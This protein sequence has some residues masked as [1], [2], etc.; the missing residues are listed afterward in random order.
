M[1]DVH[2]HFRT[3]RTSLTHP[4]PVVRAVDGVDLQ[5]AA[6]ETL[7]LVGESGCGKSTLARMANRLLKPTSG[8][9]SVDGRDI[10]KLSS[11][12]LRPVRRDVAM[13]FQDPYASLNP[14]QSVRQIIGNAFRAQSMSVKDAEL[15]TLVERVG[16]REAHLGRYPHEFSGGQRQ[17]IGLAR[18][19]ALQPKLVIADEPTSALDVSVRA[20]VLNLLTDLQEE[21]GLSYLLVT[22]DLAVVK[23]YATR[24]AVMYLGRMVE[25][26]PAGEIFET[27]RHPYTVALRSAVPEPDPHSTRERI[28]LSGEPPSPLSVPSGCPFRTRCWKAQDICAVETPPLTGSPHP[29]ACHFP[30]S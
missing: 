16:L 21:L 18:A 24:V 17:R 5:I 10:T 3:R 15:V 26:G 19:L 11:R 23:L 9:V 14:G 30:E 12:Q 4:G 29:V 25:E 27:P 7:G 28:M 8:S 20:Q 6:G 22:H 2:K 13:V 1:E